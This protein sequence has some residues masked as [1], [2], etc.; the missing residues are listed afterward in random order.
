[1]PAPRSRLAYDEPAF[2]GYQ[3][4]LDVLPG[5][6]LYGILLVPKDLAPGERR[7]VVVCQ[8]GLEG[9]AESTVQG[10]NTSYRDFAARL[11][12]RGFIT[13]SPQHLYR[14]GDRF[15]TLQRKANPLGKSLFS[16]MTAQHR[17]LLGWLGSLSFVDPQ[18]IA[19]YG[20]SYGGKS[21]MRIPAQLDGYCLSICSSDFSDWI[22][23]TVS[24][25]FEGGYLAH[26]E[27]E[28]FEFDLGNTFNYGEMAAL[29]CPRPFMVEEFHHSGLFAERS[30]GEFAR[31]QLLYENLGLAPLA[32]ITFYGA[33]QSNVPYAERETFD[34]LHEHLKWKK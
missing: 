14:S 18:R 22:W 31:V 21:A 29:I 13:F 28:I 19:F 32:R 20:I 11:A 27:Y 8:H 7:P 34:F 16:V 30:R 9:R 2:R 6:I 5:V 26:A 33:Y 3:V 15:R 4:T 23:R 12:R 24:N 25:R 10:D 17:Q 1:K